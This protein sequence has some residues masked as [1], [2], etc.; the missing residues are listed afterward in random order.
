MTDRTSPLRMGIVMRASLGVRYAD[1]RAMG[2][3]GQIASG[4][5][6]DFE[7]DFAESRTQ[8]GWIRS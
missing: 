3:T 1:G 5:G 7:N 2:A 6:V 4:G 8:R